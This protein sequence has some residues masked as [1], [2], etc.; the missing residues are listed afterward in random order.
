MGKIQK[1]GIKPKLIFS[2][3]FLILIFLFFGILTLYNIQALSDITRTIYNHPLVVSNAAF[4]SNVSITKMHRN[5]KDIVLFNDPL[6]IKLSIDSVNREE[7]RA[8]Q[9]LDIVKQ[10]ILGDEG[11]KLEKEARSLLDNW[12]H[13]RE[14]V[15]GLVLIGQH[16]R[17][18]EIT[19]GKGADHVARLEEKI[20]GLTDYARKKAF[21]F[22]NE[23]GQI[24]SKVIAITIIFLILGTITSSLIAF[25]TLN[26]ALAAEKNIREKEERLNLVVKVSNDAPWDWNFVINELYYSP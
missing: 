18:A 25:F 10:K 12:K 23:T 21:L 5:T 7:K 14:E 3:G 2:F 1:S 11:K 9:S 17:A 22:M 16:E 24:H 20:I 15:I 6:R 4:Q 26:Q 19:I 13:I 8:Y